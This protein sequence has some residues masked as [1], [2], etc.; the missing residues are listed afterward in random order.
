[1]EIDYSELEELFTVEPVT[2]FKI[3][4]EMVSIHTPR[5][6]D[7]EFRAIHNFCKKYNYSVDIEVNTFHEM[8][9]NLDKITVR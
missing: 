7:R 3:F 8:M 6:N 5:L 1:M 4:R 2:T 9:I